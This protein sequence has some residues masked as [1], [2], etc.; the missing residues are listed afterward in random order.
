[1]LNRKVDPSVVLIY[2]RGTQCHCTTINQ[3][4]SETDA[5]GPARG[6]LFYMMGRGPTRSV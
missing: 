3:E 4:L 2:G 1:M 5:G 6:S